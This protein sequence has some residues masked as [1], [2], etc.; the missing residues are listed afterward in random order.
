MTKIPI[1]EVLAA[2]LVHFMREKGFNQSSLSRK[3]KVAQRTIGNYMKPGLREPSKTGKLPSAKL[4]EVESIAE[5]L[6]VEVW[7]LLR[8]LK[9]AEREFYKQ[10]EESYSKL[11]EIAPELDRQTAKTDEI[12]G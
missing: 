10:V 2:N 9:P 7:E 8:P 11:R 1:N 5:G 4:A 3:T 12:N 6:G